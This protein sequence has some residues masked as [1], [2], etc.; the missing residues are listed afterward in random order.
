MT[1]RYKQPYNAVMAVE[2]NIPARFIEGAQKFLEEKRKRT[3]EK[4]R[5]LWEIA[6]N[7]AA[8]II[9]M[10]IRDFNPEAIYQWG[11]VLEQKN[12]KDY[13]DIDIAIEGI[14][15][16]EDRLAIEKK[17][18]AITDFPVDIVFLE[19]TLPA[20]ADIIRMKGKKVYGRT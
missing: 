14:H 13:S 1:F 17:A 18:R 15:A 5:A 16:L 2:H 12:F 9:E 11:S 10:I 3:A 8:R 6:R 4:N 20:F 19:K 7:D